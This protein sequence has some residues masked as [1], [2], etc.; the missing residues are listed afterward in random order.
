M[1]KDKIMDLTGSSDKCLKA[2]GGVLYN[3]RWMFFKT[4]KTLF[5]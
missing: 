2:E 3:F 5:V 1:S 4:K